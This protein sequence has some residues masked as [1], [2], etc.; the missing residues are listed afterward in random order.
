M[1]LFV[2]LPVCL[3]LAILLGYFNRKIWIALLTTF[4]VMAG[5]ERKIEVAI[6]EGVCSALTPP[7]RSLISCWVARMGFFDLP[8]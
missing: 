8:R 4:L 3:V 2:F 5:K 7:T 1:R 6:A